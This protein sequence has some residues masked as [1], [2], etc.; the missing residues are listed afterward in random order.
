MSVHERMAGIRSRPVDDRT[1]GAAL[2]RRLER[3]GLSASWDCI[4]GDWWGVCIVD[5]VSVVI[6]TSGNGGMGAK[7]SDRLSDV[8]LGF[9]HEGD[10]VADLADGPTDWEDFLR[11]V[12]EWF[13]SGSVPDGSETYNGSARWECSD[14]PPS[15]KCWLIGVPH[16]HVVDNGPRS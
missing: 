5:D 14:G 9:I 15:D 13:V 10:L 7:S 4:G 6:V 2:V 3:E 11:V 8:G 1:S 12:R 16:V